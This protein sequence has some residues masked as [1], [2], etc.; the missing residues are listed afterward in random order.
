METRYGAVV[1]SQSVLHVAND[2]WVTVAQA[3]RDDG[4]VQLSDLTAVD[5]LSY[6][7]DRD[8]PD[9]IEPQR[10][11]VAAT[12]LNHDSGERI[13]MRTQVNGDSPQVATLF[14]VWPG[15]ET[16]EREVFDMFGIDFVGHPD[17]TRIL[18]P[19]DWNGHPLR[20]DY[21]V[22]AIPVQFKA[23]SNER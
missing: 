19:E 21:D 9:G 22:G 20:K 4:F 17:M 13:R 10:F 12:L 18:M 8:L 5:Y 2:S 11:E 16:L 7:A 3:A 6:N 23:A 14:D 15:V 1:G